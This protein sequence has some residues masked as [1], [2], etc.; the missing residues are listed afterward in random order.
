MV[1]PM[2]ALAEH[3]G[4]SNETIAEFLLNNAMAEDDYPEAI[5]EV[6]QTGIDPTSFNPDHAVIGD[7]PWRHPGLYLQTLRAKQTS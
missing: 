3:E 6:R 4:W 7:T 2:S 5:A 1:K